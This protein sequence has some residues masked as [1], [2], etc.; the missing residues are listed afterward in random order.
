MSLSLQYNRLDKEE[1]AR[2]AGADWSNALNSGSILGYCNSLAHL[3]T[4]I[5]WQTRKHIIMA[6][7]IYNVEYISVSEAAHRCIWIQK[8]LKNFDMKNMHWWPALLFCD[9]T[10][11]L[12][13]TENLGFDKRWRHI[14]MRFHHIRDHVELSTI[15]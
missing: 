1:L 6:T 9:G 4:Q 11:S 3:S 15:N 13:L 8:S 5:S 10:G 12:S 7:R 14:E 2:Y